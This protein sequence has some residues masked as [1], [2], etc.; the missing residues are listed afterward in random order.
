[1]STRRTP[2]EQTAGAHVCRCCTLPLLQ[3]QDAEQIGR[4]WLVEL[5]CPNCG[6]SGEKLLDQAQMDHL[7]EELDDGFA[8]L[9]A[10]LAQLTRTNMHEYVERFTAALAADSILPEDF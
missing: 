2:T 8:V 3:T 10:A 7:D 4:D 5:Y 1:M 6:W 9:A